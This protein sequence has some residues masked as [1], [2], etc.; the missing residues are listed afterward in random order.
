MIR[1]FNREGQAGG[2]L[3]HETCLCIQWW[4]L[5]ISDTTLGRCPATE[6][7]ISL[8]ISL[9]L[10]LEL[11]LTLRLLG[12]GPVVWVVGHGTGTGLWSGQ[13]SRSAPLWSS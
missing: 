11:S 2:K 6:C 13:R 8:L 7:A 9:S 3:V 4:S 1:Q 12:S 10:I 5:R